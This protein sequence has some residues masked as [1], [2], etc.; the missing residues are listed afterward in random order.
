MSKKKRQAAVEQTSVL[1]PLQSQYAVQLTA[2]ALLVLAA[3]WNATTSSF[4]FD[5]YAFLV[6]GYVTQHGFGWNLFRLQQTRPLT[7]LTFHWNFLAGGQD[8]EGYHWVNVFIHL[9]N[10]VLLLNIARRYLSSFA[11]GCVASLFAVHPLQTEAVTYIFA[12]STLLSTHFALWSIWFYARDRGI[13]SAVMYGVSLLAKEE[14]VALPALFLLLDFHQRRRPRIGVYAL[15]G[16]FAAAAA[17]RLFY[18]IHTAPFDPGVGR[19]RG[20]SAATYLLTQGRVLWMYLRLVLLPTGL[21][22]DRDVTLSTGLLSPWT[23]LVAWLALIA[24]VSVLGWFA[25]R[26][27]PAAVWMLGFFALIAPSS[28]IV[29]QADL[30]FEHR[31]YLPLICLFLAAGFLMERIPEQVLT[32]VLATPILLMFGCT[33]IRNRDWHDEKTFWA[34]VIAKSPGKSRAYLGL[35]RAYMSDDPA[36]AREALER[37]LAI[38]PTSAELQSNYGIVLLG[39]HEPGEALKHFQSALQFSHPSADNFNNIGAA[40][41]SLNDFA[42]SAESYRRAL[43]LDAC[44]Y[45]ARRNLVMLLA[46]TDRHAAYRDGEVPAGCHLIPDQAIELERFRRSVIMK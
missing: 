5:D 2:L 16:L 38:D 10:C 36:K 45:N 46:R 1:A 43:A 23:T 4:H 12:R 31:T 13:A 3:Y 33:V 32:I 17:G 15:F 30:M 26:K 28:S 25:W 35:A 29:P 9:A 21:N 41:Y 44:N 8:P 34:V 27:Q 20:I 14:T 18:L 40:Y 6:D 22:L 11:A 24:F 37:G 42:Q 39:A 7:Y 19:V